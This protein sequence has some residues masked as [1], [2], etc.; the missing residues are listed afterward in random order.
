MTDYVQLPNST[1]AHDQMHLAPPNGLQGGAY[2]SM[3]YYK[4]APLYIQTPACTSRQ[5]VVSGKRPYID[6]MFSNHD[7]PFL[8]W[9][10][11]MEAAAVRLIYEKRNVWISSD[12]E[13]ADIEAGFTS[14]VRPYKGGK[15]YLIRA[16]I[17]PAKH[18]AS[19]ACSVFDEN[20]RP[21][22]LEYIKPEQR[23]YA[24]LEFQGIKFT[25]RSFQ[26][27]V[28]L[29]Q[30][31][32]VPNV[33]M[34]QSCVIRKPSHGSRPH[35]AEPNEE[36]NVATNAS[37]N[38]ESNVATNEE[39]NVA[40]NE[41]SNASI[42][43]E[44]N[45]STNASINEESNAS[46]N[47]ESNVATNEES[48]VATNEEPNASINSSINSSINA[49]NEESNA[50]INAS[51]NEEPNVANELQE[52]NMDEVEELEHMHMKLKKPTE[53]YYNMYRIAKQ[54][55]R[56]LKKNAIAAYLEAKQIKSAHMLEDSSDESDE[57][58]YE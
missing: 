18:L 16:H 21:V 22:P 58:E 39:S 26:L 42:N 9:L 5:G 54:K 12:I 45:A 46:I 27:E 3:L 19:P 52:V 48:N 7:V 32:I 55:A 38:E 56:E 50:S 1:F 43:E 13:R 35:E 25:A 51:I 6:L 23:M 57:E 24:V 10:E 4:D 8:E 15:H 30:V 14:P 11:A 41:E 17:Q 20:E 28:S 37:T 34:F 44:S 31:L 2:F 36:P 53:V 47:E 40:I 29:K 49:S 33:P